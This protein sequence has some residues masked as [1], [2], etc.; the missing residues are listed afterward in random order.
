MELYFKAP[1]IN[2]QNYKFEIFPQ[3]ENDVNTVS[4]FAN[5]PKKYDELH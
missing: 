3:K 2:N 1:E 4:I 5:K